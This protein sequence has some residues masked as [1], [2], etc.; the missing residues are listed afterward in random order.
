MNGGTYEYRHHVKFVKQKQPKI[1]I[2][3]RKGGIDN[4]L[5]SNKTLIDSDFCEPALDSVYK[6]TTM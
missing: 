2:K 3:A 6:L 4:E 5:D 1:T